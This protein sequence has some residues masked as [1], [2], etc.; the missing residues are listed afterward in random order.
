MNFFEQNE[1]IID[2]FGDFALF[3]RPESKVERVSYPCMT[4]S[5]AR[6]ILNAI[7]EKPIEFYYQITK[8]EIINPIKTINIKTNETKE[9]IDDKLSPIYNELIKGEKG[10]TQRNNQFLQNVYYR[11][12]AKIIKQPDFN[13]T[14]K[15]LYIQFQKRVERGKC[16]YQPFLGIRECECFFSMP[17]FFKQPINLNLDI[18][19]MLY[20]VFD[21]TKNIKLDTRKKTYNNPTKISF[22]NAKIENGVLNIPEFSS[23]LVLKT[24]GVI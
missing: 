18:G 6:G 22:F 14:L 12:Y 16:F 10:L 19:L 4:P 17:D 15:Q 9:K 20:D 1:I 5:A 21:I 8:I 3:T 24:K 7:Y 13:G 23:D 2:V 11:I